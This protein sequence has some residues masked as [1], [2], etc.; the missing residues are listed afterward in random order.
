MVFKT[1]LHPQANNEQHTGYS[2]NEIFS[3]IFKS[4]TYISFIM[5]LQTFTE[6]AWYLSNILQRMKK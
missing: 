2:N 5:C 6:S 4:Y 1:N 3:V